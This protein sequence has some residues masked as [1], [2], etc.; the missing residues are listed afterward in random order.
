MNLHSRRNTKPSI[1]A[2]ATTPELAQPIRTAPPVPVGEGVDGERVASDPACGSEEEE[3]EVAAAGDAV[4]VVHPPRSRPKRLLC[5]GSQPQTAVA[6][7]MAL[8]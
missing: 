6:L 3:E 7:A 1:T 8:A 5:S 4:D 2:A